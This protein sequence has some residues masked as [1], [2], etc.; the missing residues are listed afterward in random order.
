[1]QLSGYLIKDFQLQILDEKN[2]LLI[3]NWFIS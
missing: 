1:M 3:V 2:K